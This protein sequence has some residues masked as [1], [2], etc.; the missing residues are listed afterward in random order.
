MIS[1]LLHIFNSSLSKGVFPD[2]LKTAKVVPIFKNGDTLLVSNYRPISLLNVLSKLLEW[3]VYRRVSEFF[4]KN[5]IFV[6][7]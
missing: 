5:G 2:Q 1:P 6:Q 7:I 4:N 3:L